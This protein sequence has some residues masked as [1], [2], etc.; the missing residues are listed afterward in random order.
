MCAIVRARA[1]AA[2][3]AL[4]ATAAYVRTHGQSYAR[5]SAA[6]RDA[7]EAET[8]ASI[9]DCQR[10]V[11]AARDA[12]ERARTS[13][14]LGRGE[15]AAHLHGIALTLSDRLRE[16]ARAFDGVR[17]RRFE[18][19]LA[20]AERERQ[21]RRAALIATYDVGEERRGVESVRV[22][23]IEREQT[24]VAVRRQDGLE[25]ELTQLLEQVRTAEK[26][27]MEMSALSSLFATHVQAQAQ[28]IETLY[29][30]AVESSRHF[31]MGNVEMKKTIERK[32]DAQRY[33]AIILFI[34]TFGL[35]FLDWYSG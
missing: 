4:D 7:F 18:E 26:N 19:T 24:Q 29:H 16:V 23:G 32:G 12:I 3:A 17:E 11:G 31:E 9:E 27:V 10:C 6:T 2:R 28:Q 5:A 22:E 34:A 15:C 1:R 20:R 14:G 35:L 30:D 25:E 13:G 8:A 33:V 21:R